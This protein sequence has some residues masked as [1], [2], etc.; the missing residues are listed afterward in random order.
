[1]F[2]HFLTFDLFPLNMLAFDL[3][4]FTT[5]VI[6]PC[7]QFFLYQCGQPSERGLLKKTSNQNL[8]KTAIIANRSF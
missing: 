1:M 5:Y 3:L 7:K 6:R 8:Q 2:P 4:S